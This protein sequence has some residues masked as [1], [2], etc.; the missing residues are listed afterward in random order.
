VYPVSLSFDYSYNQIP[1]KTFSDP[2]VLLSILLYGAMLLFAIITFKRKNIYSF[3]ILMFLITISIGSNLFYDIGMMMGERIL[4][5]PSVFFCIAVAAGVMSVARITGNKLHRKTIT[6]AMIILAPVTAFCSWLT[7]TRNADWKNDRTLALAD[8]SKSPQSARMNNAAGAAY[9]YKALQDKAQTAPMALSYFLKS[10][11][12]YPDNNDALLNLSIT[13]FKLDST[14]K[15]IQYADLVRSRNPAHP[16]LKF[17]DN[18][19]A[20]KFLKNAIAYTQKNMVDSAAQNYNLSLRYALTDSMKL[21]IYYNM[22][23]MYFNAGDYKQSL[24]ALSKVLAMDSSYMNA[25][26]GYNETLKMTGT[27]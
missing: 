15:G 17:I 1:L 19:L 7:I 4:F 21:S 13:Y 11:A 22:G 2:A 20:E 16:K 25:K 18:Y 26:T 8:I 10:I 23:G 3:C 5:L 9:L 12:I 6:V 27:K 24:D 14:S